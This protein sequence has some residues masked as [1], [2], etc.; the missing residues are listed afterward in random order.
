[1]ADFFGREI[2]GSTCGRCHWL[3]HSTM[4]NRP[5]HPGQKNT[6]QSFGAAGP[7]REWNEGGRLVDTINALPDEL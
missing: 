5:D 7:F 2:N 6:R 4:K 3:F 1:M